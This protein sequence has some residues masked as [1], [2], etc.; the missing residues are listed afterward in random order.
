M[1]K[2]YKYILFTMIVVA[3]GI[4]TYQHYTDPIYHL[5]VGTYA[6]YDDK[7]IVDWGSRFSQ[8]EEMIY[9]GFRTRLESGTRIQLSVTNMGT[10]EILYTNTFIVSRGFDFYTNRI[11]GPDY[12]I[13]NYKVEIF[14]SDELLESTTFA[15]EP[16]EN[17]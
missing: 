5:K 12:P 2:L 16:T 10:N 6:D 7:K 11:A 13:G 17:Q 9:I 3:S 14:V 1:G 8:E 15:I 4:L